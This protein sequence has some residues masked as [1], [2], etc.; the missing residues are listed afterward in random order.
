MVLLKYTKA[1]GYQ[2]LSSLYLQFGSFRLPEQKHTY[3]PGVF[4]Q[5]FEG[6]HGLV[7]KHSSISEIECLRNYRVAHGLHGF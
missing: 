7:S 5:M 1:H 4:T 3:D 6:A 2:I